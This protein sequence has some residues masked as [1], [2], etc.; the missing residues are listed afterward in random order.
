M[1]AVDDIIKDLLPSSIDELSRLV[2]QPGIS[3]TRTGLAE[4]AEMVA[5]MLKKRGFSVEMLAPESGAPV[6][7]AEYDAGSNRTLLIYNHYDVQPVEPLD[8]WVSPPFEPEIR[9]GVLYGR[10]VADDKGHFT[11]RLLAIDALLAAEGCLPCNIKW[12]IEG[13]EETTSETLHRVVDG[14]P[15]RFGADACVWEYGTV[16]ETGRPVL[17]LG[18]RGICYVELS[19]ETARQDIHSGL[20]GSIMPNAAWR[21]VWALRTIKG[22]DENVR[23]PGFYAKVKP[24][25][26]TT[27]RL[28]DALPDTSEHYKETY[29]VTSFIKGIT[30]GSELRLAEAHEPSCTICGLTAGYQG[31]GP[32]TIVPARASAKLD[33]R[34]VPDQVP[35]EIFELLRE[36]LDRN[37]FEDVQAR[38]VAKEHPSVTNPDHPF[39]NLVAE[40]AR[41]AYGIPMVIIPAIGGSGP[42]ALFSNYHDFPI[43]TAGV[44]HPTNQMH[45]PNENLRL[46]LYEKGA[47][48]FAAI[49]K[50]FGAG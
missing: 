11:N 2:S 45:S 19:V 9:E 49:L 16:D 14:D 28:I 20:G 33:F 21:L 27:R 37:G 15:G 43:V 40:C 23:I 36:H 46:D 38:L 13:E 1:A 24:V 7:F 5:A 34:L 25:T 12:V 42:N 30:G 47:R 29:G 8:E 39:V 4:C 6:V 3:S 10:G 18:L 41:E 26:A 48:H 50:A 44:G 17:H 35:E 31:D 22:M 32:K